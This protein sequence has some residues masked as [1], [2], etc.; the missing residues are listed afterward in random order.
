MKRL[1]QIGFNVLLYG[2]LVYFG[3]RS[4]FFEPDPWFA[5]VVWLLVTVALVVTLM[6][7]LHAQDVS[8]GEYPYE[9]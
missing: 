9:D 6:P 8:P 5:A 2:G 1:W 3:V 7:G 4:T